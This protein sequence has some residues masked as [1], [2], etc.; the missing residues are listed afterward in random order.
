MGTIKCKDCGAL[1]GLGDRQKCHTCGGDLCLN[2]FRIRYRLCIACQNEEYW[3]DEEDDF[4]DDMEEDDE[5][6]FEDD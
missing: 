6:D 4:D 1:L 2:C 3:R 5:D